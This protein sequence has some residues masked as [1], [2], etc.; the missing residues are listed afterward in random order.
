MYLR[1]GESHKRNWRQERGM[2][3][4]YV[5]N[6]IAGKKDI[7]TNF[8]MALEYALGVPKSFWLNLQ[9]NYDAELLELNQEQT[10]S[11]EERCAREALADVVKFLR[12]KG[13]MPTGEKKDASI[14]SLRK[15]LGISDIS[16]L[17]NI[18]PAGGVQNVLMPAG[19]SVCIGGMDSPVPDGK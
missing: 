15:A 18:V 4:A 11:E 2:T 7:S 5:S 10:I 8:A 6:V 19:K 13:K 1:T 14:L 3:P 17:G 16:R 12:K 9:A